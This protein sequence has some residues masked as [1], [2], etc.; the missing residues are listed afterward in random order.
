[1]LANEEILWYRKSRAKWLEFGDRNSRYFHGVTTIRRRKNHIKSLKDEGGNWVHDSYKLEEMA[2]DYYKDFFKDEDAYVPFC[3]RNCFPKLENAELDVLNR[4]VT[5]SE[6][7]STVRSIGAFKALGPDGFQA[8]FYHNQWP[9]I[10]DS[11]CNLIRR[12]FN[13]PW[14]VRDLN[15]MF[16]MLIPKL[17]EVSSMKHFRPIG[18][19]NVSYKLVTKLLSRRIRDFLHKLIGLA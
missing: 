16:I 3:V 14:N 15:D 9:T 19:C 4:E 12:C 8:I 13:E 7:L 10:G 11:V 18:L 1:M 5:N 17:E 6:I 2:T